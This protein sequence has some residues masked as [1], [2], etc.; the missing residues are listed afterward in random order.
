[1]TNSGS[2]S[3][4]AKLVF[5]K[6]FGKYLTNF[7]I[8]TLEEV[9]SSLFCFASNKIWYSLFQRLLTLTGLVI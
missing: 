7:S 2:F 9:F 8:N 1:M 6:M 4:K 5:F 3:V